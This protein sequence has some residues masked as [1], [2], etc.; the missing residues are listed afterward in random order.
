MKTRMTLM[1]TNWESYWVEERA[2]KPGI[3]GA[4]EMNYIL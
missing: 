3:E 4:S 1:E 2:E